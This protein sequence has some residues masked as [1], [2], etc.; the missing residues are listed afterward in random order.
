[1][2]ETQNYVA[3]LGGV[4]EQDQEYLKARSCIVSI[5]V[6]QESHEG[7]KFL[8]TMKMINM[9][10]KKCTISVNDTLQRYTI[11]AIDPLKRSPEE[12]YNEAK[13]KGDEW[14]ERNMPVITQEL[15]IPFDVI[16]WD[17]YLHFSKFQEN[18]IR[19]RDL[20]EKNQEYR[21]FIENVVLELHSRHKDGKFNNVTFEEF[22]ALSK[23]YLLEEC[24][25]FLQWLDQP[26]DYEL[27]PSINIK[28]FETTSAFITG[29]K[30]VN[31]LLLKIRLEKING[32]FDYSSVTD[33]VT[34]ENIMR[35]SPENIYWKDKY[36]T[37]I[38]CNLSQAKRLR[39][40]NTNQVIGKSDFDLFDFETALKIRNN[41]LAVM[42]SNKKIVVEEN[43]INAKHQ[44][45]NQ[46]FLS[47]KNP[48]RDPKTNEVMGVIGISVDITKQK[49]Q[50][51]ELIEKNKLLEKALQ[52]KSELLN[53][54]S[55]EIKTPLS[56]ILKM[57]DIL[58]D[59]WD[60]YESNEI[61]KK[62]LKLAVEANERLS[63][64]L[65][66]LLDLSQIRA[67]KILYKKQLYSLLK[68][69]KDVL[70]EFIEHR[71]K[72]VINSNISDF[73]CLYDHM[74]IEQVIRNLV[75]N[76]TKYGGNENILI[77]IIKNENSLHFSITDAGVGVPEDELK[78]IFEIFSQ[79]SRTK[80]KAGG[81][82][83]GLSICKTIIND[84]GGEIGASNNAHDS[85][86]NFWFNIPIVTKDENGQT[87][88]PKKPKTVV[89]V[90]DDEESVLGVT[91]IVLNS[92][93]FEVITANCG[94]DG[95]NALKLH[96][97]KIDVVL[98]DVM[99]P[100]IYGIDLLKTIK[101]D[102]NLKSIP[103]LMYSGISDEKEMQKAIDLGAEGCIDKTSSKEEILRMLIKYTL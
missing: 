19:V 43:I 58:Y 85:G 70:N 61:R 22:H 20:Y 103:I 42:R 81:S 39:Y 55:H 36:G 14:L 17:D 101:E 68:S 79:S 57:T 75:S 77:D 21:S 65:F 48:L 24:A 2:S 1:M 53:N 60:N 54:I 98:L 83:I 66:N 90:V 7:E 31:P 25:A 52:A 46:Y 6:G 4:P 15:K 67:G 34:L 51:L 84:H 27:Y 41:D 93:G 45:Q 29:K 87:L 30:G 95:L 76:A 12:L 69:T 74:R 47:Y 38:G 49:M 8:A 44:D 86:T 62:H 40:K 33:N 92:L 89:L 96:H 28:C 78:S 56:S 88:D 9:R 11:A 10:F 23:E 26:Y 50:E 94:V 102:A 82:G 99:M 35:V 73:E 3:K 63:S 71:H 97:K 5:S 100:D 37:T 18:N 91:S 59:Q 13:R 64:I 16:R 32:S 80:N 72:F